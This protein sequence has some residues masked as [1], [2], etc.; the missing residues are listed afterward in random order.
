MQVTIL[1]A[2]GRIGSLAMTEALARGHDL[3][4]LSLRPPTAPSLEHASTIIGD[5]ADPNALRRA[6]ET[7]RGLA[8]PV[9]QPFPFMS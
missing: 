6:L 5:T 4:L 3:I 8:G 7:G 1:G 2:T 9:P